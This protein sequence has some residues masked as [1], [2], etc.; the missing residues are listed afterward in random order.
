[1]KKGKLWKKIVKYILIMALFVFSFWYLF[2]D[3]D[4]P[5][6]RH[7]VKYLSPIFLTLAFVMVF[8]QI[9]IQG[10]CYIVMGRGLGVKLNP[11]NAYGYVSVDLFFSQLTPFAVGGQPMMVYEMKRKGEI[12][13]AKTTPMVLLY[14][15]MNKFAL[16]IMAIFAAIFYFN[17]FFKGQDS[18]IM[19]ALIIFG[20]ISNIIIASFSLALMVMGNVVY[21]VGVR[22]I[23][24]LY[25][26]SL[27]KKPYSK[28]YSLKKMVRNYKGSSRYFKKHIPTVF[29]VFFLCVLKRIATF[30]IAYFIYKGLGLSGHSFIYIIACQTVYALISDS[31]PIPGGIG[32]AEI[33]IKK[34]YSGIYESSGD[35]VADL[36]AL[37][38]RGIS[39]YGLILVSGITTIIVMTTKKKTMKEEIENEEC[40]E[41]NTECSSEAL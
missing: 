33:S 2:K 1:M 32:A 22:L 9:F 15:F 36:A 6:I 14:S 35:A 25:N 8:A 5:K 30:A 11:F 26:H 41:K 29:I 18:T 13:V 34:L 10:L 39:Y 23:F 16:I 12:E 3:I 27:I 7:G 4:I 17:D 38:V 21:K 31:F 20:V 28:A 19:V 40:I 37:L 24:W